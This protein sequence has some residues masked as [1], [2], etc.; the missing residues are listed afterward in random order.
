MDSAQDR[1][2]GEIVEA[3]ELWL[4]DVV[5]KNGYVCRGCGIKVTPASYDREK[6]LVR[7]Y[8]SARDGDH[9]P[10]CDVYGER[11]FVRRGRS[12]RLSNSSGRFPAPYPTRLLLVDARTL[13]GTK[14][15]AL[16]PTTAESASYELLSGSEDSHQRAT[17]K[18]PMI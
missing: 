6:N 17:S 16:D 9:E 11:I 8:F 5:D 15:P 1:I 4:L 12:E 10:E 3:E 14:A 7:P 13:V 2:T 18:R